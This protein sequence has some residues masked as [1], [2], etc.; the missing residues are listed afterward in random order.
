MNASHLGNAK[1]YCTLKNIV[2]HAPPDGASMGIPFKPV[3]TDLCQFECRVQ[4]GVSR[5]GQVTGWSQTLRLAT[6]VA[7][8]LPLVKGRSRKYI[9]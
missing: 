3:T 2:C 1:K 9:V 5:T 8:H 4:R 6:C 7:I